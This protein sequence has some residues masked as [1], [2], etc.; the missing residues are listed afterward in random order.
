LDLV[1]NDTLATVP[2]N[3]PDS[4]GFHYINL[5]NLAVTRDN[6]RQSVADLFTLT[7]AL[8]SMDYDDNTGNTDF[9]TSRIYFLGHSLG[10]IV[11]SIFLA[12]EPDVR[13]AVLAMPGA[14][15]AKLLDGSATFGPIIA[16]GLQAA[17]NGVVKGTADY[18]AFMTAAQ[19]VIDPADPINYM[20][21]MR[22]GRGVLLFEV[23]GDMVIP[24]TVPDTNSPA[25]TVPAPLAGTKPFAALL[26]LT[27]YLTAGTTNGSDLAA[28]VSFS[29]PDSIG[30]ANHSSVL[31]P[32]DDP[33]AS[34]YAES[35][36]VYTEMQKEF[37]DFLDNDGNSLTIDDATYIVAP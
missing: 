8:Q 12:M 28:W 34:G 6:V 1:D 31:K 18:E 37:A 3:K 15:L 22:D 10:G 4:S 36:A 14:G 30:S 7:K 2:D 5:R 25:G 27:P 11:G 29:T 16:G 23:V 20:D 17:D 26:G 13:D 32:L 24:N 33:L 9:D 35:V 19:T 21:R